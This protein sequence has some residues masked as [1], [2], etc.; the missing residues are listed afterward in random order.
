MV[1]TTSKNPI[2]GHKPLLSYYVLLMYIS[3]FFKEHLSTIFFN[4]ILY[5]HTLSSVYAIIPSH[6][7]LFSGL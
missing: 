5:I 3:L 2:T 7:C 1:N 4:K 6:V